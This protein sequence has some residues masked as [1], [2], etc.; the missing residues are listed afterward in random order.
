MIS[1]V[2][3]NKYQE[4]R[5]MTRILR[6][7]K[8]YFRYKRMKYMDKGGIWEHLKLINSHKIP[9]SR[10]KNPLPL[11]WQE[12]RRKALERAGYKC[13][14]CG[15]SDLPLHVHHI[16]PRSAGGSHDLSN[17]MVLCP[18]CHSAQHPN[19]AQLRLSLIHI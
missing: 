8:Q 4:R 3:R 18:L 6:K 2:L 15:R 5:D 1:H 10:E 9:V 12:I 17:L 19:N 14:I 16:V 7:E 11:N 13:E